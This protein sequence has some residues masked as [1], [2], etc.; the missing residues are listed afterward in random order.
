MNDQKSTIQKIREKVLAFR[1]ER[2]WKQFHNAKDLT[3]AMGIE[4]G[5]IGRTFPYGE[6]IAKPSLTYKTM[7]FYRE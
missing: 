1:D 3:L 4:V 7:N 5:G 6:K 2:N